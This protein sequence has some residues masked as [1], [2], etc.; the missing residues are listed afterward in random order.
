MLDPDALDL[1]PIRGGQGQ[2]SGDGAW[3]LAPM[4]ASP[5][6]SLRVGDLGALDRKPQ[7]DADAG[8]GGKVSGP[9]DAHTH[10]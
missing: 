4:S 1:V 7:Q 8:S 9:H 2:P 6:D 3:F 10:A 5:S